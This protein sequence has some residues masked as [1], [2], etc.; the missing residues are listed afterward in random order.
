MM[1]TV[2][3]A[4]A[5]HIGDE[6]NMQDD[7]QAGHPA[8]QDVKSFIPF[9][10]AVGRGEKLKRD[11]TYDESVAALRMILRRSASDAQIGA[12]LIAQRVKGEAVDEVR[13]FTDLLRNE[14]V[15]QIAPRVD[16]LLDLAPP[17]DGKVKTAQLAP[18]VAIVLAEAGVPVLLHGDEGVPT[19][20]GVGP[21]VV[22]R[23]LGIADDLT[24]RQVERMVEQTGLGYLAAARFA[25]AY[26]ALLPIRREFGL[27]TVLNSVEKLLNPANAP[28]Q[29]SGF[30]HANYVDRLRTTQTGLRASWIVQ[31]E[32]GSIEMAAGRKTHIFA[33][34]PEDDLIVDPAEPGLAEREKVLLAPAVEEHARLNFAVLSGESGSAADQ[35]VLTAGVMLAL[36]GA[37]ANVADG[38]AQTRRI[39]Q[40]G[41]AQ[42]RFEA[43]RA[44]CLSK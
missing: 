25:P 22:L 9:V 2:Q 37:A 29:I 17:Y 6:E 11:L 16:G 8:E 35:V 12:F 19:K 42:Q 1:Q 26:H 15:E 41:A 44:Y 3:A 23:S 5:Y 21:G 30:F 43:I 27:R 13:G 10:K 39:L 7:P 20:E 36:L 31:G 32:E 34:R 14:F 28:Y 38:A 40:S 33:V 18:A 24:P 4:L